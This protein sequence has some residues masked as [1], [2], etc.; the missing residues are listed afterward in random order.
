MTP[1]PL[2]LAYVTVAFALPIALQLLLARPQLEGNA[3]SGGARRRLRSYQ[4]TIALQWAL[5]IAVVI[6]WTSAGRSWSALGMVLPSSGWHLAVTVVV[7]IATICLGVIQVR[8]IRRIA[9]SAATR[10]RYRT[11][12]GNTE[13]MNGRKRRS[14]EPLPSWK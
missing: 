3:G 1:T 10:A 5:S 2:D 6:A 8:G 9:A 4:R 11:R 7:V 14:K 13:A 12:F